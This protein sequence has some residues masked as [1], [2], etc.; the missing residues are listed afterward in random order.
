MAV[1]GTAVGCKRDVVEAI[2]AVSSANMVKLAV[3]TAVD[4]LEIELERPRAGCGIDM[5]DSAGIACCRASG[6]AEV[7]LV[8]LPRN[9]EN[10][11]C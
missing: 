11:L 8:R 5:T 7:R 10:V 4:R 1:N 3:A 9:C 2:C 6:A